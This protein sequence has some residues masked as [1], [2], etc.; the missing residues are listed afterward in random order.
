MRFY[1]ILDSN[2]PRLV[3][4]LLASYGF[5]L[6]S[7]EKVQEPDETEQMQDNQEDTNQ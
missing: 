4:A 3:G 7:K 6:S 5:A 1:D 2:P